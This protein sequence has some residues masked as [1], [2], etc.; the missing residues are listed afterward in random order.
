[1]KS[2]FA[3]FV[4]LFLF[5]MLLIPTDAFSENRF[6]VM[7]Q[8]YITDRRTN[9]MWIRYPFP[10]ARNR[11]VENGYNGI[12][13]AAEKLNQG[14]PLRPASFYRITNKG[15]GDWEI[16]NVNQL[17]TITDFSLG[18]APDFPIPNQIVT[19]EILFPANRSRLSPLNPGR[20]YFLYTRHLS[21]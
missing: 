1:M 19:K 4:G 15:Y 14:N 17:K 3:F 21:N 10:G 13:D 2:E 6:S 18:K 5:S 7:D 11:P 20:P 12:H 9:L 16:A 8:H